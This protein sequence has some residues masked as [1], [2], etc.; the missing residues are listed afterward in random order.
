MK[1]SLDTS[2]ATKSP[3]VMIL[4][5]SEVRPWS[6]QISKNEKFSDFFTFHDP[7]SSFLKK[8]IEFVCFPPKYAI[9]GKN[10]KFWTKMG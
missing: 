2:S 1:M 8:Q 10:A 4:C 7:N 5:F 3:K 6:R 9:L